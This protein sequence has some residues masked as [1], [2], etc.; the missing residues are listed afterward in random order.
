MPSDS[1]SDKQLTA[2]L[3]TLG[4]CKYILKPLSMLVYINQKC[5]DNFKITQPMRRQR[6]YWPD[7]Q[8]RN[9]LGYWYLKLKL[10]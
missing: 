10:P 9:S 1:V 7:S 2:S 8:E 3:R 6:T 5:F 4:N